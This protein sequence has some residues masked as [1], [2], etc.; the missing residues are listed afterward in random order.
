[1]HAPHSEIL[2]RPARFAARHLLHAYP[3]LT[4]C[5]RLANSRSMRWLDGPDR[6]VTSRLRNRDRILVPASDFVG[7]AITYFGDLDPKISR[8]LRRLLRP[9]D[10]VLDV[11][12]NVGVIA[13]QASRLVGE[14]GTVHAFEPQPNLASLLR[15]SAALNGLSNLR[16][17]EMALGAEQ[18]TLSLWVPDGNAGAASLVRRGSSGRSISVPVRTVDE[19]MEELAAKHVRLIKMDVEGFEGD[20]LAGARGVLAAHPADVIVY[21]LLG[22][23]AFAER[24]T[25]RLLDDL[26]YRFYVIGRQPWRIGLE[27]VSAGWQGP[28][29]GHDVVAVHAGSAFGEVANRLRLPG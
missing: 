26:G 3:L 8:I 1:M 7:R 18:G 20:V 27:P 10:T 22:S 25:T 16:V 9:G 15:Q 14:S 17:H 28:L 29:R 11:G 23:E 21:E 24:S 4:G 6:V 2:K 13:L 5:G 12:A 19:V